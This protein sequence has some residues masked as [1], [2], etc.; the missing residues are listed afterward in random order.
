MCA[1]IACTA[2]WFPDYTDEFKFHLPIDDA[3]QEVITFMVVWL[4]KTGPDVLVVALVLFCHMVG[5][6]PCENFVEPKD[7]IQYR[8]CCTLADA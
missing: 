2:V 3:N 6:P 1:S 5:H 4:Q 8:I 7:V